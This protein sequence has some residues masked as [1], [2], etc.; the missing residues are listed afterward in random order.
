MWVFILSELFFNMISAE[1]SLNVKSF[2]Q[3]QLIYIFDSILFLL[4]KKSL[5]QTFKTGFWVQNHLLNLCSSA[6]NSQRSLCSQKA[7]KGNTLFNN[8]Q[9]TGRWHYSVLGS[10]RGSYLLVGSYHL[11]R[12]LVKKLVWNVRIKTYGFVEAWKL[13]LY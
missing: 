6:L 11:I 4:Y 10:R 5:K 13:I 9:S 12:L 7:V 3:K 8:I 1:T 2:V